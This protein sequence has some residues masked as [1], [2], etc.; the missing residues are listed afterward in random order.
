MNPKVDAFISD[1]KKWQAEIEHLRQLLLDC[2]LTEEF[3]WRA[4][5]YSFQGNNV[6]LIGCFKNY[7]ALSFFKGT[8]LQDS[9]S[10]LSKPGE[11]S[12]AMRFFKFTNAQE[13]QELK[14]IIKNYIYE[15][16]EIEKAGLKVVFKSNTALE[17]VEE[18]QIV[19]DKNPS[20]NTAFKALTPGRQRAYNLYFSAAKQ[21]KT[22]QTRIENYIPRIL[23]RKGINDCV[24]GM[25]KKMPSC[26]GSHKHIS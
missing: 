10:L 6:V 21:S 17:L 14:P 1:A 20:L 5:C 11:N 19:L 23:N 3:K 7:C 13:I 18:F 15:A 26:D 25:S 12:Q 2:G 8:L 24:C 9:N 16:I 4:P 22:R